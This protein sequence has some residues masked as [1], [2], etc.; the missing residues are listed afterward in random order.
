MGK[1]TDL[2]NIIKFRNHQEKVLKAFDNGARKILLRWSRRAGKSVLAWN[3]LIKEAMVNPGVYWFCFNEYGTAKRDIWEAMTKEGLKFLDMIP[4]EMVKRMNVQDLVIELHNGSIIRL[5]GLDKADNLVGAGLKGVVFDEYAV[6]NPTSTDYIEAMLGDTGGWEIIISTPRGENHFFDKYNYAMKN[7][8]EWF[9]DTKHCGMPEIA[10]Y[11]AKGFLD[12]KRRELFDKYGNH[13]LYNQEYMTSFTSPNA[14]SVFGDLVRVAADENRITSIIPLDSVPFY[15]AWDLGN[16]LSGDN[17]VLTR[18]GWVNI[19]KMPKEIAVWRNG[20]TT[21]E[22]VDPFS[23]YLND[24]VR[25]KGAHI[26][27]T[28]SP[29]HKMMIYDGHREREVLAADIKPRSHRIVKNGKMAETPVNLHD[30]L[31]IMVQADGCLVHEKTNYFRISVKKDRKKQRCEE[32]LKLCRIG[33][34]KTEYPDGFTKYM[35]YLP[36]KRDWKTLD[37]IESNNQANIDELVKWDGHFA[38]GNTYIYES[39]VERCADKVSAMATLMGYTPF[40]RKIEKRGSSKGKKPMY[41]V[42]FSQRPKAKYTSITSVERVE[43]DDYVYCFKTHAGWFIARDKNKNIFISGNA[44]STSIVLFQVDDA[45]FPTI[46]DHIENQRES[47][48]WYVGEMEKRKWKVKYHFLPHD[49]AHHKGAKN[50]TYKQVLQQEGITNTVILKKPKRVSD[51]LN[52]LRRLFKH[53]RINDTCER[54]VTCLTKLEYE[55]N[56]KNKIWSDKPTHK[57]GYSD[58]CIGGDSL[59]ETDKGLVPI[60]DIKL[61]DRVKVG[62]NYHKTNSGA[63]VTGVKETYSLQIGDSSVDITGNHK[64]LTQRG[65]VRVDNLVHTDTICYNGNIWKTELNT[66]HT[67]EKLK[68]S[69]KVL[70]T[71]IGSDRQLSILLER[72]AAKKSISIRL[73]MKSLISPS[74]ARTA[75]WLTLLSRTGGINQLSSTAVRSGRNIEDITKEMVSRYIVRSGRITSGKYRKGII[76]TIKTLTQRTIISVISNF[77]LLNRTKRNTGESSTKSVPKEGEKIYTKHGSRKAWLT[78][79]NQTGSK[80]FVQ[81][82]QRILSPLTSKL[83]AKFVAKSSRPLE[84]GL[85]TKIAGSNFTVEKNSGLMEVWNMTIENAHMYSVDGIVMSN[86]DSVCYMAQAIISHELKGDKSPNFIAHSTSSNTVKKKLND[87]ELIEALAK[88]DIGLGGNSKKG[89]PKLAL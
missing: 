47:V 23:G 31:N 84:E 58:T 51:K 72:L 32:L 12:A 63:F 30:L 24:A 14:G 3:I 40:V 8:S 61:G 79:I 29:N 62:D 42:S 18:D 78:G 21:F 45:G 38:K 76:Y 17:E 36:R 16:C 56:D 70:S 71:I 44:D 28:V 33:Y 22:K 15:T 2:R 39:T 43:F 48:D 25:I 67:R 60:K 65:F 5:I 64:V 10:Q 55:W 1:I 27:V 57:G 19:K 85:V 7:S 87:D 82:M 11:M 77:L 13:A 6:L 20:I 75:I 37:G 81:K 54:V 41:R 49:A 86:C 34:K 59:I 83:F 26:D 68:Q 80:S 69:I 53:M 4:A 35:F 73:F 74:S 46:I 66:L 9:A 52:F 88:F 50:E 89:R